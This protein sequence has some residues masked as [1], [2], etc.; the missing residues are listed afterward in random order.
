MFRLTVVVVVEIMISCCR[1]M[2]DSCYI[3]CLSGSLSF[4]SNFWILVEVW[5]YCER[6]GIKSCMILVNEIVSFWNK[7]IIILTKQMMMM[8]IISFRN[9]SKILVRV[10]FFEF[11]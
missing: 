9:R 3:F 2:M 4:V 6:L 8:V 5:F 10:F 7:I 11:Q 1:F